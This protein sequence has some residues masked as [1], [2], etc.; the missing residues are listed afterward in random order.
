MSGPFFWGKNMVGWLVGDAFE[1]SEYL[2][3]FSLQTKPPQ[4]EATGVP[5]KSREVKMPV[6]KA[7]HIL[8][9]ASDFLSFPRWSGG[10]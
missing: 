1:A 8:R 3:I 10:T 7:G 4:H 5:K 2:A 9:L 6:R